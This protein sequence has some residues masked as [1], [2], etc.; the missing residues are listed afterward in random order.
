MISIQP[1]D[2]LTVE[3]KFITEEKQIDYKKCIYNLMLG[4]EIQHR[5]EFML[6]MD[7]EKCLLL[8]QLYA[9]EVLSMLDRIINASIS[10]EPTPPSSES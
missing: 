6:T 4:L 10:M 5:D 2:V 9:K 8:G 7:E 1:Q 3:K